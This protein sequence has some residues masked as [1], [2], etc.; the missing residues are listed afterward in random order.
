MSARWADTTDEEDVDY[1]APVEEPT[2]D[3]QEVSFSFFLS[4]FLSFFEKK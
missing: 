1:E 4:F 3:P 2:I